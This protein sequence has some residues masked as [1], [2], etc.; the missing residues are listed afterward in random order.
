MAAEFRS[1]IS[2]LN[3]FAFAVFI[4]L[5][6]LHRPMAMPT[7]PRFARLQTD[8][9]FRR[10]RQKSFKVEIDDRFRD[11]LEKEEFGGSGKGKGRANEGESSSD[12]ESFMI[13]D[14]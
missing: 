11:V 9:R 5:A 1:E 3:V 7:D 6:S 14:C 2:D 13:D 4:H 8:P 12:G 10:P